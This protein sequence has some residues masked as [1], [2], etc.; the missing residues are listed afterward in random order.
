MDEPLAT[1]RCAYSL[2]WLLRPPSRRGASVEASG[3]EMG[4]YRFC[5]KLH[6]ARGLCFPTPKNPALPWSPF[7]RILIF[8]NDFYSVEKRVTRSREWR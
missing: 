8:F 6:G 5:S 3:G 1:P 7:G 2:V 4:G